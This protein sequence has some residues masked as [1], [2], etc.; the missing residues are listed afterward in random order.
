MR[1]FIISLSIIL[2]IFTI[3]LFNSIY[4]ENATAELI[5]CAKGLSINDASIEQF[6]RLWDKKQFAIRLSSSHDETHKIDEALAV[7]AAKAKESDP[8]GFC[9]EKAL[10]IEYLTQIQEDEKISIDSII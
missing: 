4:V 3:T 6:A 10:L 1:A 9:E 8:S 2:L 7:L 5:S